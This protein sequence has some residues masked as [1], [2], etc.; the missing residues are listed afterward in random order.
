MAQKHGEYTLLSTVYTCSCSY[1]YHNS[2]RRIL[3]IRINGDCDSRKILREEKKSD[4]CMRSTH[5]YLLDVNFH[6]IGPII[7]RVN[8][9]KLPEWPITAAVAFF[10]VRLAAEPTTTVTNNKVSF[11]LC[12]SHTI[13][14]QFNRLKRRRLIKEDGERKKL[15]DH[16]TST[17]TKYS[18]ENKSVWPGPDQ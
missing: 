7:P 11:C 18:N 5:I 10:V 17:F 6:F 13:D 4:I 15:A 16:L 8:G 12:F 2:T 14:H 3:A 1:I 9:H